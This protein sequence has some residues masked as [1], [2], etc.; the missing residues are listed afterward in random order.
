MDPE[1][2]ISEVLVGLS[3]KSVI[4]QYMNCHSE[5][6][7]NLQDYSCINTA[8]CFVCFFLLNISF[9]VKSQRMYQRVKFTASKVTL[10]CMTG[11]ARSQYALQN[12][13][14]NKHST[15]VHTYLKENEQS[16]MIKWTPYHSKVRCALEHFI[17]WVRIAK[18]TLTLPST[19]NSSFLKIPPTY[20][21][22][23]F[24]RTVMLSLVQA[25]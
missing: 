20:A 11:I 12:K 22:H 25:R 14:Y 18:L 3:E 1:E 5:E 16:V 2:G 19:L 17:K 6:E 7:L 4:F 13:T 23:L 8:L 24:Y 21:R 10:S 9:I 15:A